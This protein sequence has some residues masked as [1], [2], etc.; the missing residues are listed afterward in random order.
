MRYPIGDLR[1]DFEFGF[2][3]FSY[4]NRPRVKL[5]ARKLTGNGKRPEIGINWARFS[6]VGEREILCESTL[7]T[8]KMFYAKKFLR[9]NFF[10][11]QYFYAKFFPR[12]KV[13]CRKKSLLA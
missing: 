10:T 4:R 7:L 3:S 1:F 2:L 5:E 12:K 11:P 6:T 9:Q 13:R 8:P